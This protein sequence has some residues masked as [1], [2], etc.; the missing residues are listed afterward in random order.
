MYVYILYFTSFDSAAKY[1]AVRGVC[2][3][4]FNITV[5]PVASAG[6]NF[7]TAITVG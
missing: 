6:A 3:A 4:G 5:H 7:P 2:S 1:R